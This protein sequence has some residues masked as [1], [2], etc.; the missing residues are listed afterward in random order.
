MVDDKPDDIASDSDPQRPKRAPP[1]LD[2]D[3]IEI[4]DE[5]QPAGTADAAAK[6]TAERSSRF[7]PL[8]SSA[9]IAAIFG[10]GAAALVAWSAGR[11]DEPAPAAPAPA[12]QVN[13]A[14]L[15]AL[16]AR[17]DKLESRPVAPPPD[18]AALDPL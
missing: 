13:T 16:S 17:L 3:A 11:P 10:A 2:L 8:L 14:A 9:L 1:T 4:S 7:A 5:T 12:Q 6:P 18:K 15:D